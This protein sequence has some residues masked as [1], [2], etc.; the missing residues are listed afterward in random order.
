MRGALRQL[1]L[2][3]PSTRLPAG[4]F[5]RFIELP[6]IQACTVPI[7]FLGRQKSVGKQISSF[8][9]FGRALACANCK[10]AWLYG[11]AISVSISLSHLL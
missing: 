4:R 3:E 7:L 5:L 6:H 8:A 9:I 10:C 2:A 11:Q 1:I